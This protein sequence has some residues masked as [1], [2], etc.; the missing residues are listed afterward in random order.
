M[1]QCRPFTIYPILFTGSMNSL[2][3][4]HMTQCVCSVDHMTWYT[5]TCIPER[6]HSLQKAASP[7]IVIVQIG[8]CCFS[9]FGLSLEESRSVESHLAN[10]SPLSALQEGE[11]T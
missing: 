5:V 1:V 11:S 8:P 6:E 3:P 4:Y 10:S 7:S 9:P 2:N